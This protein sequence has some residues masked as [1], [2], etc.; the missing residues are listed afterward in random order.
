MHAECPYVNRQIRFILKRC[1]P[2]RPASLTLS[3][4]LLAKSWASSNE[5]ACWIFTSYSGIFQQM[6]RVNNV[7]YAR[8]HQLRNAIVY[9]GGTSLMMNVSLLLCADD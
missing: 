4:L 3:G 7:S 5:G 1:P 8:S 2:K 6:F 9:L